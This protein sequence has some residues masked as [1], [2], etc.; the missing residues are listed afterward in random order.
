MSIV[1]VLVIIAIIL[2]ALA[3]FNV[4]TGKVS[5]GWLGLA[6]YV[7]STVWGQLG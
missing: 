6:F 1:L 5:I 7:L 4:P 2:L 3:A